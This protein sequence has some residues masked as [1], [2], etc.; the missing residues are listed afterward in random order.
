MD[1]T[2][3]DDQ[4]ALAN[5]V[6]AIVNRHAEIR[7]GPT[8]KAVA[9]SYGDDL[10]R[11]LAENG[12][13]DI[14]REDSFGPLEVAIMIAEVSRSPHVVETVGSA[15]VAPSI[16]PGQTLPR[17][18]A[19]ARAEDLTRAVRFLDRARTV[20]VDAGDRILA[21][22]IAPGDTTEAKS[23]LACP[24]G[25]FLAPPDLAK[26][27][28][29]DVHPEEF[30]R[31]WQLGLTLEISG[32]LRSA[33]AF[34]VD[35]VKSRHVFGRPVGSFQAVQHRLAIG[36]PLAEGAYWTGLRAAWSGS[37]ID[38]ASSLLHAQGAI[39]QTIYDA[40]QFNGALGF[41]LEHPLHFW[42]QRLR[43]LE[44]ELGGVHE[45]AEIVADLAWPD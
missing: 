10:D 42:T 14:L 31:L 6:T 17:P 43:L 32:A 23:T 12:F 34:T 15:L 41:T 28:E 40:Q 45:Q 7:K 19:I 1:L 16:L 3:T 30:R 33:L 38:A 5:S 9:Y 26:G 2:F 20:L 21:L 37:P 29:I 18:I 27:Q 4:S 13:L 8:V 11:D 39:T 25:R 36:T 44:G 22:A 24:M 35:Y